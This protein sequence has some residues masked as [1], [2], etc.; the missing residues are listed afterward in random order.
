M[1]P[2]DKLP[3]RFSLQRMLA[4]ALFI[5]SFGCLN[6]I[7]QP[8]LNV[9]HSQVWTD[10]GSG[11][12]VLA[13]EF[14]APGGVRW[15]LKDDHL[16]SASSQ[17]RFVQ[18]APS[19]DDAEAIEANT[20]GMRYQR[21]EEG[22]RLQEGSNTLRNLYYQVIYYARKHDGMGPLD[23][24]CLFE[25]AA[26]H[27]EWLHENSVFLVP[28]VY[29]ELTENQWPNPKDPVI[30]A[31]ETR[32]YLDDGKH[33]MIW[34]N[35]RAGREVIDP[36]LLDRYDLT[37]T[38]VHPEK[39]LEE[40]LKKKMERQ[41]LSTWK[42]LAV[43]HGDHPL[44]DAHW[45]SEILSSSGSTRKLVWDP[46]GASE[47][48]QT[49]GKTALSQWA[50]SRANAWR[51]WLIESDSPAVQYWVERMTPLYGADAGWIGNWRSRTNRPDG[52][53]SALEVFG[54]RAAIRETL[55]TDVLVAGGVL[56]D[57]GP[58]NSN[59][60][61]SS[62]QLKNLPEVEVRS[63]PFEAM[64]QELK[65]TAYEGS[66]LD[67]APQ[68]QF[69]VYFK[70]VELASRLLDRGAAYLQQLGAGFQNTAFHHHVVEKTLG[71][72]GLKKE[73]AEMF[74]KKE[75]VDEMMWLAGDLFFTEGADLTVVIRP[76]SMEF[77]KPILA[78]AAKAAP[79]SD[80]GMMSIQS[81]TGNGE[82][83]WV[84]KDDLW[85][86]ATNK[87]TAQ[88]VLNLKQNDGAGG[89]GR[90]SEFRYLSHRLPI[91]EKTGAYV[92][93]S[94]AF[95]RSLIGPKIKIA[96]WRR[97]M[98]RAAMEKITYAEMLYQLDH[99]SA[100]NSAETLIRRGYLPS[101]FKMEGITWVAGKAPE[102]ELYGSL[103]SMTPISSIEVN[104]ASP[105]EAA[106]YR[107]YVQNYTRYWSR[108]FDPIAIRLNQETPENPD[109]QRAYSVETFILP[110]I[111]NSLYNQVRATLVSKE[112]A[113]PLKVP[114]FKST[115]VV[116]LSMNFNE[117][118]WVNWIRDFMFEG[119]SQFTGL[120]PEMYDEFGPGVTVALHDTDPIL[121]IGSGDLLGFF[122]NRV[123]GG[124]NNN[125][126]MMIS[127][128][129]AIFTRP[130]TIAIELKNPD[131]VL[132][133]MRKVSTLNPASRRDRDFQGRFYKVQGED[134]WVFEWSLA[135]IVKLRF[136]V[137][138][139]NGFLA[140]K[141]LPWNDEGDITGSEITELN[142]VQARVNPGAALDQL[143]SL[144]TA[145][146]DNERTSALSGSVY[147]QTIKLALGAEDISEA[148]QKHR[149]LF[150]FNTF[151]PGAGEWSISDGGSV[152][153]SL[154]GTVLNATQ[155]AYKKGMRKF[156]LLG[157]VT[158]LTL[159]TQLE[160]TGLR[161]RFYW[162][163]TGGAPADLGQ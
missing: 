91:E 70:D 156:G 57:S 87:E 130:T 109:S 152:T 45:E 37:V 105:V 9:T 10:P 142:A 89:L 68:D 71:R 4:P 147:L 104:Q 21:I 108:F 151:H 101:G 160:E 138:V 64:W 106:A 111:E 116:S 84:L 97:S 11:L 94:D 53:V 79:V 86:L 125:D 49:A 43:Y 103:E 72:L 161:A 60:Q 135:G 139:E 6:V 150:G 124:R 78:L 77:L 15:S 16:T 19:A 128:L 46:A 120:P 32:P 143:P 100:P 8:V 129:V 93:F 155:P 40:L 121:A 25:S 18:L 2:Q 61:N 119:L 22:K 134:S 140:L 58:N 144:F 113:I 67:W 54:G 13:G 122:K 56:G 153:S 81:L 162:E 51:A 157:S 82:A 5:A 92:Y 141:N 48:D 1:T 76:K 44:S 95:I 3:F 31:I 59:Q 33:W 102:H 98:A 112:D 85:I 65:A 117:D 127:T 28:G 133:V 34:N 30:L 159:S 7:A 158:G 132:E 52:T 63:H 55:Q 50:N 99:G 107:R 41:E 136:G 23:V 118:Q 146:M 154:F 131:L 27:P 29:M 115:P 114:T 47:M 74:L 14:E 110:L 163:T 73:W 80:E 96:Q 90:S 42:T 123:N 149:E 145:A 12:T 17:I 62:V 38:P 24:H 20:S 36:E 126:M 26:E 83:Y 35:G 66:L 148:Q 39:T 75:F 137:E 88:R 69:V